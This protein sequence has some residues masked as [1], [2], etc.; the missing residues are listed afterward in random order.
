MLPDIIP[1]ED[2]IKTSDY[3][4]TRYRNQQVVY[5]SG[6]KSFH[7]FIFV[8]HEEQRLRLEHNGNSYIYRI[9][10]FDKWKHYVTINTKTGNPVK[11]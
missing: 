8:F 4:P 9:L 6:A 7:G 1:F 11:Q 5:E 3:P 2:I 10:Q